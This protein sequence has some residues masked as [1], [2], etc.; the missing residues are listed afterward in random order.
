MIYHF[1]RYRTLQ[2]QFSSAKDVANVVIETNSQLAHCRVGVPV[3][4]RVLDNPYC[5][6][7]TFLRIFCI[8]ITT[9]Q[10][11][12]LISSQKNHRFIKF[13]LLRSLLQRVFTSFGHG[14]FCTDEAHFCIY[15]QINVNY[16]PN[17]WNKIPSRYP[18]TIL[19]FWESITM[20]FYGY[21]YH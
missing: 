12:T 2:V 10:A 15:E 1:S 16:C 7:Q 9:N 19:P 20:W 18:E 11:W 8:F 14:K 4:S 5:T 6:V 21:Y 3:V 13:L 17:L